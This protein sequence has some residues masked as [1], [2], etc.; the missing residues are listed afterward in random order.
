MKHAKFLSI[1]ISAMILCMSFCAVFAD[2]IPVD[3]ATNEIIGY[4]CS[5][6]FKLGNDFKI[7]PIYDYANNGM[8]HVEAIST[9][10]YKI[11]I[12][13]TGSKTIAVPAYERTG[14]SSWSGKGEYTINGQLKHVVTWDNIKTDSNGRETLIK[15]ETQNVNRSSD[16]DSTPHIAID[17]AEDTS[18]LTIRMYLYYASENET[19]SLRL[20]L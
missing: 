20:K 15:T 18:N 7:S 13:G 6:D 9:L 11:F 14:M 8:L 16:P 19:S 17:M 10:F 4:K 3:N 1:I 12:F 2:G 5:F